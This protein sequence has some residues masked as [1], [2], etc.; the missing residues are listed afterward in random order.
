[1]EKHNLEKYIIPIAKYN[2]D[3]FNLK[4]ELLDYIEKILEDFT[5]NR[6]LEL[7]DYDYNDINKV[8]IG[9]DEY[10]Y[11][12]IYYVDNEEIEYLLSEES[13]ETI[14]NVCESINKT[15]INFNEQ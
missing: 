11:R 5:D 9:C 7:T 6:E 1:M 4:A 10:G 12:E 2:K 8:K 3:V 15:L 13:I 14:I